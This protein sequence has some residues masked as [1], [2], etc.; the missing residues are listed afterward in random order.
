MIE[1]VRTIGHG[2]TRTDTDWNSPTEF[3]PNV[4]R[5]H[6]CPSSLH[7]PQR[8]LSVSVRVCPCLS[9]A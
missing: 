5:A 4:I 3:H 9:V 1:P 7:R 2:Q 6:S 8:V